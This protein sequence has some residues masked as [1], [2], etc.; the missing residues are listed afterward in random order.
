MPKLRLEPG[1]QVE[2]AYYSVKVELMRRLPNEYGSTELGST[3]FKVPVGSEPIS[4]RVFENA[5][6]A[7]RSTFESTYG[8]VIPAP[9]IKIAEPTQQDEPV[10]LVTD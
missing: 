10:S 2:D 8:P 9:E 6:T 7:I 3:S 1:T 5:L 4:G